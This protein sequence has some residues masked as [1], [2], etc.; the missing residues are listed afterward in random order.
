MTESQSPGDRRAVVVAAIALAGSLAGGALGRFFGDALRTDPAWL[1]PAIV[2]G[3][4][5]LAVAGALLYA[6][7]RD[8]RVA[9]Q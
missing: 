4:V 5:A 3:L 8:A 6:A 7:R 1:G 2:A 9:R